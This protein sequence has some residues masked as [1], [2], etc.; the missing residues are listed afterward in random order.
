MSLETYHWSRFVKHESCTEPNALSDASPAIKAKRICRLPYIS[1]TS[2]I[3]REIELQFLKTN[4]DDSTSNE[5]QRRVV[6][7]GPGGA[8]KTQLV[9]TYAFRSQS[10]YSAV[11]W[12]TASSEVVLRKSFAEIAIYLGLAVPSGGDQQ[13]VIDSVRNWFTDHEQGDWLLVIDNA[14]QLDEVNIQCVIPPINK[15]SVIITSRNREAAALGIA[16]ELGEMDAEDAVALLFSRADI[17]HPTSMEEVTGTEITKRLGYL[18]LA[19]EHAGAYIHSVGGTLQDYLQ[20]FESSKRDTLEQAPAI[21]MHKESVLETF[22]LS[23]KAVVKRNMDAAKLLCFIGFLDAGGVPEDLLTS[24]DARLTLFRKEVIADQKGVLQAVR[25]LISFSL[26]RVK[27]ESDKKTISLHPLVH[28]LSRARMNIENQWRW[29]GISLGWLIE[30]SVTAD[31]DMVHFPHVREQMRQM[32][33][34]KS[35]P[36]DSRK[37]NCVIHCL[38]L[39]QTHY[40]FAWQ[41][42]GAMDELYRYSKEFLQVLEEDMEDQEYLF[43]VAMISLIDVQASTVQYTSSNDTSDQIYLRHL[44]KQMTPLAKAAYEHASNDQKQKSFSSNITRPQ[45]LGPSEDPVK[46]DGL[47]ALHTL[48][49]A[50]TEIVDSGSLGAEDLIPTDKQAIQ[51]SINITISQK[52]LNKKQLEGSYDKEKHDSSST[53][54]NEPVSSNRVFD[55]KK[56]PPPESPTVN[57][58]TTEKKHNE[59]ASFPPETE[60]ATEEFIFKP[61]YINEVFVSITPPIRIQYLLDLLSTLIRI[62]YRHGRVAEADLLTMY[63]ILPI[64]SISQPDHKLLQVRKLLIEGSRHAASGDVSSM[65]STCLQII[66]IDNNSPEAHYVSLDYAIIMNKLGRP[67]EAERIVKQTFYKTRTAGPVNPI[68]LDQDLARDLQSA[69]VWIKKTLSTSLRLQGHPDQSLQT[70]LQTLQTAQTV[71]GTNSLSSL[72]AALLLYRFYHCHC[73]QAHLK[74]GYETKANKYMK[75]FIGVL[76]QLYCSA[77]GDDGKQVYNEEGLQMSLILWTQGAVEETVGILKAFAQLTGRIMG[78]D[79]VLSRKTMEALAIAEAEWDIWREERVEDVLKFGTIVFPR[80]ME[81]FALPA[82]EEGG[83]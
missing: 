3:G 37:R 77:R 52:V 18:A 78:E 47:M 51:E 66:S 44:L 50:L 69:Y 72:H 16:I 28:Y 31:A 2:F 42:Y 45:T 11:F 32:K 76:E 1:H 71:F 83:S 82:R 25:L 61:Q 73:P 24:T 56:P 74:A 4:L 58:Q 65:L 21:S 20:Q 68:K 75:I 57:L 26:V 79:D 33:E 27:V 39:L 70:L 49:T 7:W 46:Q 62:H 43:V 54:T 81:D 12:V 9:S 30:L 17:K 10:K 34:L 53:T 60:P 6:V 38:A 8:G 48:T 13:T 55:D 35:F 40:R 64:D 5:Q 63:S 14:D 80:K 19:I 23:F 15:G 22:N 41:N 36:A 29:K 59:N 67:E